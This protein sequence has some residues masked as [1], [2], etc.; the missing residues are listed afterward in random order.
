MQC[1]NLMQLKKGISTDFIYL[2]VILYI[3]RFIKF[4]VTLQVI[5]SLYVFVKRMHRNYI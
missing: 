4:T 2:L 3:S 1:I 5:H